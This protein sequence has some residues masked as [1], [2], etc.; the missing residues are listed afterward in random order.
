MN[1]SY[2]ASLYSSRQYTPLGMTTEDSSSPGACRSPPGPMTASQ[3]EGCF[4]GSESLVSLCLQPK[5]H[6]IFETGSLIKSE[7]Q[8]FSCSALLP[9]PLRCWYSTYTPARSHFFSW[10]LG[11]KSYAFIANISSAPIITKFSVDSSQFIQDSLNI[12]V[13]NLPHI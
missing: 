11:S 7:A 6:I 12:P 2:L 5:F 9:L 8:Q 4:Q 1:T 13:A 3:L 10:V